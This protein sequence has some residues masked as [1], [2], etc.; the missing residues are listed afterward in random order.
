MLAGEHLDATQ[1]AAIYAQSGGN[2]FY[3]LQL[4]QASELPS[5]SSTGDRLA[6]DAGVP[7]TVAAAL[8]EEL[9]TLTADARTVV[10]LRI[11]RR[12]SVRA[13]ARVCDRRIVAADPGSRRSTSCSTRACCTATDVPRRFRLPAPAR[14]PRRA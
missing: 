3:T 13:R 9:A 14:A 7:R 12:R 1:R 4:A 5:R 11:D 6:L 2:P 10:D 8:L